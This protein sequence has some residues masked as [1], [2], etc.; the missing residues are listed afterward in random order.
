MFFPFIVIIIIIQ[1]VFKKINLMKT[2][3]YVVSDDYIGICNILLIKK[4]LLSHR[5]L[6]FLIFNYFMISNNISNFYYK[7]FR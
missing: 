7:H 5:G 6:Y 1:F 4:C 2:N 3:I